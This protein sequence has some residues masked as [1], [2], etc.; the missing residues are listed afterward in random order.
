MGVSVVVRMQKKEIRSKVLRATERKGEIEG[1][2]CARGD[3]QT[4]FNDI[5]THN[6]TL[7][8]MDGSSKP[9]CVIHFHGT[10]NSRKSILIIVY[11]SYG[12]V[13]D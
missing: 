5:K 10:I 4:A 1:K 8:S 2:K 12:H 13:N 7:S 6:I 3:M 9:L 11:S